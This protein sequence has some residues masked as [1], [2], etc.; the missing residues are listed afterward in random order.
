M[1]LSG[2]CIWDGHYDSLGLPHGVGTMTLL[3]EETGQ[4]LSIERRAMAHGAPTLE[5]DL[6]LNAESEDGSDDDFYASVD[7]SFLFDEEEYVPQHVP[8]PKLV[9]APTAEAPT[10]EAPAASAVPAKKAKAKKRQ[11]EGSE[12]AAPKVKKLKLQDRVTYEDIKKHFH[13]P[14]KLAADKLGLW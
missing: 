4:P 2:I 8:P 13:L 9:P 5:E 12:K 7:D 6:W 11:R 10:A 14:I 1:S 3:H